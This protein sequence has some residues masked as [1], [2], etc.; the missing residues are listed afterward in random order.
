MDSEK[1]WQML[2]TFICSYKNILIMDFVVKR[3]YGNAS[4]EGIVE[5]DTKSETFSHYI[6][7]QKIGHCAVK[8]SALNMTMTSQSILLATGFLSSANHPP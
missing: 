5:S 4:D 6:V 7:L 8:I 2:R 1:V 3:V